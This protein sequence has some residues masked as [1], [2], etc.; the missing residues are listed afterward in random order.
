MTGGRGDMVQF[1]EENWDSWRQ[2]AKA[3]L[4]K[5]VE[6]TGLP[7]TFR[8][9]LKKYQDAIG[10]RDKNIAELQGQ[11]AAIGMENSALRQQLAQMTIAQNAKETS[12]SSPAA[13]TTVQNA[14]STAATAGTPTRPAHEDD[15]D[16]KTVTPIKE[17]NRKKAPPSANAN[18]ELSTIQEGVVPTPPAIPPTGQQGGIPA[19][20]PVVNPKLPT[21]TYASVARNRGTPTDSKPSAQSQQSDTDL[22]ATTE[23]EEKTPEVKPPSSKRTRTDE[24]I[25]NTD[26]NVVEETVT[27]PSSNSSNSSEV[28]SNFKHWRDGSLVRD[29]IF[30]K[31]MSMTGLSIG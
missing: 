23:E 5:G 7:H 14:A 25:N 20:D 12:D 29:L 26:P 1:L 8:M 31:G 15:G 6:P 11:L 27:K 28:N 4:A 16:R 21:P 3:A 18:P 13:S 19:A 17:D 9:T 22:N 30:R 24:R 10:S 2:R